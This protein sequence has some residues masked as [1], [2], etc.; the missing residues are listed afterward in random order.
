MRSITVKYFKTIQMVW[1]TCICISSTFQWTTLHLSAKVNYLLIKHYP[2]SFEVLQKKIDS[3]LKGFA[4]QG[5][6]WRYF[7]EASLGFGWI[8][9]LSG[10]FTQGNLTIN[11]CFCQNPPGLPRGDPLGVHIDWCINMTWTAKGLQQLKLWEIT[12]RDC[13]HQFIWTDL[14]IYIRNIISFIW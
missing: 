4:T 10:R 11:F 5:T 3:P 2:F 12:I 8:L 14:T 9:T 1:N 6:F 7:L 13:N